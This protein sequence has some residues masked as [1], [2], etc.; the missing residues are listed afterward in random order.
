[1]QGVKL[2]ER[3]T[4]ASSWVVL[5]VTCKNCKQQFVATCMVTVAA[6]VKSAGV[7][8]LLGSKHMGHNFGVSIVDRVS[9]GNLKE[10]E[11]KKFSWAS[12]LKATD[13]DI[14]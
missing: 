1:V 10:L 14:N 2:R 7:T 4:C 13:I 9:A 3:F 12:K 6:K 11:Q 5:V 8:G